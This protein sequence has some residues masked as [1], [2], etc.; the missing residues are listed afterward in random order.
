[1]RG[2]SAVRRTTCILKAKHLVGLFRKNPCSDAP[3]VLSNRFSVEIHFLRA[4]AGIVP[5]PTQSA[6]IRP[7]EL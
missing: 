4:S 5:D 3:R 7:V 2:T 1:M 6:A